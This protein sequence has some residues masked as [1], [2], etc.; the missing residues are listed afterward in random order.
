MDETRD[1]CVKQIKA[2]SKRQIS[3]GLSH[4]Q[5][6]FKKKKIMEAERKLLGKR[7]R[8]GARG[9]EINK[10]G[11]YDQSPFHISENVT[12]KPT[13]FSNIC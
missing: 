8:N 3:P 12:V 4:V 1:Y 11:R 2:D 7:K 9:R 10:R 5:F 6:R 13:I